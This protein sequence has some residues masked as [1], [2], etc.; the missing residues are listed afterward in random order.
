MTIDLRSATGR[1]LIGG[2]LAG[3]AWRTGPDLAITAAHC[4][5]VD[6]LQRG[7]HQT[8]KI[9]FSDGVETTATVRDLDPD[10]DVAILDLDRRGSP[11]IGLACLPWEDRRVAGDAR[12]LWRG[13]GYPDAKPDGLGL[14]GS[15]THVEEREG[16]GIQ[17]ECH[18]G[19]LGALKHASGSP[20]VVG[21]R[22][23]ALI[24]WNPEALAQK[25]IYAR[26]LDQV[27]R[28]FTYLR[29]PLHPRFRIGNRE[30]PHHLHCDRDSQWGQFHAC[31]TAAPSID[32]FFVCAPDRE[33]P[34]KFI[35]R[36][37]RS[38]EREGFEV[39]RVAWSGGTP[40]AVPVDYL[41]A[42]SRGVADEE[43]PEGA[44][45][46]RILELSR[47]TRL[48]IS[49]PLL[50]LS[51]A[52]VQGRLD[53][54]HHY[55]D[56]VLPGLF[57]R[58]GSLPPGSRGVVLLQPL[59]WESRGLG[60]L[61][62]YFSD[63]GKWRARTRARKAAPLRAITAHDLTRIT[64]PQV[65]DLLAQVPGLPD[66]QQA[67]LLRDVRRYRTSREILR[68]LQERIG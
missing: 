45:V 3:T 51:T 28:V 10:L 64:I 6:P 53:D 4:L 68:F 61:V 12:Q 27:A 30:Q 62:S 49:H 65:A 2:K 54:L 50:N 47:E 48:V 32:E 17:L 1:L 41:A 18:Q 33:A 22:A 57:G 24:V 56:E 7:H 36:I 19:G 60:R 8:C 5:R 40:P 67:L 59:Y 38:A 16:R 21:D 26:P 15:I 9:V 58:R 35:E 31:I 55:Y 52:S 20:V 34:E 13:Y 39:R 25:V 29:T 37:E 14:S 42:L 23:I 46:D 44:L 66:D 11:A 43:L 63:G